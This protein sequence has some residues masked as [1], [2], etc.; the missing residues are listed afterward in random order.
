MGTCFCGTL[1]ASPETPSL[2][3][4]AVRAWALGLP[5]HG[6]RRHWLRSREHPHVILYFNSA[7]V[8][9]ERGELV[10][11]AFRRYPAACRQMPPDA[12]ATIEMPEG[13]PGL[14]TEIA[15]AEGGILVVGGERGQP[16]K[17]R[18]HGSVSSCRCG[19][20]RCPVVVVPSAEGA[21]W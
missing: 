20:S 16:V 2:P 19:H 6:G 8:C 3:I 5:G 9:H 15:T 21:A 13:D 10:R 4:V 7:E 14:M 11:K 1:S 18:V 12:A 17:Q